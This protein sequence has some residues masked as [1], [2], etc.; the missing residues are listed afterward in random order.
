MREAYEEISGCPEEIMYPILDGME[1]GSNS[2]EETETQVVSGPSEAPR[3]QQDVNNGNED[4]ALREANNYVC[5]EMLEC[6]WPVD[7]TVN[8]I[9]NNNRVSIQIVNIYIMKNIIFLKNCTLFYKDAR[10]TS[11]SMAVSGSSS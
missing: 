1:M 9:N 10:R 2:A 7:P 6:S 11:S 3:D 5:S 4:E 8:N